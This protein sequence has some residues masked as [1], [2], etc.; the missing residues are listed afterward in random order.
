MPYQADGSFTV[1]TF[2][3][4][5]RMYFDVYVNQY[6]HSGTF[7][8]FKQGKYGALH[9]SSAQLYIR[10][11]I[12]TSMILEKAKDF[13]REQNAIIETNNLNPQG[14][15]DAFKE[16]L[17]YDVA[18]DSSGVGFGIAI[19]YTPDSTANMNIAKLLATECYAYDDLSLM[20]GDISQAYQGGES[21]QSFVMKWRQK[22][23]QKVKFAIVITHV[24]DAPAP[25]LTRDEVLTL[26][27]EMWGKR[28]VWGNVI[29]PQRILS[30]Q[31]VPF[32]AS[33][34]VLHDNATGGAPT[35]SSPLAIDYYKK[36]VPEITV[37]E[38]QITQV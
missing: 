6:G 20:K 28:Y 12:E 1:S 36:A 15:Q 30:T 26:F 31:D 27:L 11:E 34:Q 25:I 4:V 21:S 16:K 10:A 3:D 22:E 7:E 35:N 24:A 29:Q 32:A 19:D 13:Y 23:D 37:N 5:M 2:D 33:V 17:G 8:E 38:I 9:Y 18:L 14:I